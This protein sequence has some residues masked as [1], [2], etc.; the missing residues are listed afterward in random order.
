MQGVNLKNSVNWELV[1][2]DVNGLAW[3]EMIRIPCP[4]SSLNEALLRVLRNR[5]P[6]WTI[7]V[8]TS[9]KP[10]FDDWI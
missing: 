2:E 1:R 3:N 4:V 10:L 6:K 9:D 7:R 5:V 8:R